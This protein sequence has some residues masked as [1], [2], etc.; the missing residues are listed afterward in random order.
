M[1]FW[2]VLV[3]YAV[4]HNILDGPDNNWKTS[5]EKREKNPKWDEKVDNEGK[6]IDHHFMRAP[7]EF[8]DRIGGGVDYT[9]ANFPK[10]RPN[11]EKMWKEH[12][13]SEQEKRTQAQEPQGQARKGQ[14]AIEGKLTFEKADNCGILNGNQTQN[15]AKQERN[16]QKLMKAQGLGM[17]QKSLDR[18]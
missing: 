17:K 16:K 11:I 2:S 18:V 10:E 1:A 7:K 13:K 3:G 6:G 4:Q 12:Q 15:K 14:G 8:R 5:S 9:R